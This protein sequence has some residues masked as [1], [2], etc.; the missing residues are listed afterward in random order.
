MEQQQYH[1]GKEIEKEMN[2][3]GMS[4]R[5]LADKINLSPSAVYDIF[6]RPH[7]STYRLADIQRVLGRDFFK[8]LS[9]HFNNGSLAT[10][11]EDEDVL[12]ERFEMLMPEDRLRALDL[13]SFYRLAEEFVNTEHHKPLVVFYNDWRLHVPDR[14]QAIADDLLG[15]GQVLNV[16][17]FKRQ[18]NGESDD[19]IINNVKTM[20]HPI[21]EV[22]FPRSNEG[23]N[24]LVKLAQATDKKVYGYCEARTSLG[25]DTLGNLTYCDPTIELFGA[26]HKMIHFV[27]VDD[28]WMTY[29]KIRQLYLV[30]TGYDLLSYLWANLPDMNRSE[31]Q[32]LDAETILRW[33]NDPNQLVEF[34]RSFIET[35]AAHTPSLKAFKHM[36][37]DDEV[38]VKQLSDTRWVVGLI[39]TKND[40][41][42]PIEGTRLSMWVDINKVG[43]IDFEYSIMQQHIK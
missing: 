41:N 6:K 5:E 25:N 40:Y 15:S 12:R 29:R 23:L 34:Y 7:I 18:S 39:V 16:D 19:E 11:V 10:S 38:T 26:W 4:V 8:E 20:P 33:F 24:F 2:A 27:Y 17:Y 3:Q 42:F 30:K 43:D 32:C 9:Q 37:L 21:I 28:E 31:D 1:I 36:Y 14:I 22:V 13:Q 35:E